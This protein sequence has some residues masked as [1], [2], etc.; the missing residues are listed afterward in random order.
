VAH[1]ASCTVGTGGSFPG[2]EGRPERDADHSPPYSAA[3]KK[4]WELYLRSP[5]CTSME[6]DGTNLPF[7]LPLVIYTLLKF[8]DQAN[9]ICD[10]SNQLKSKIGKRATETS[11]G[12]L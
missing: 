4:E 7:F 11:S 12:F 5:K 6:R 2:G 10:N 3:V 8:A 1:P 9:W